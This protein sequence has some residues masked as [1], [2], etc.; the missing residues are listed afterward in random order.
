MKKTIL[1]TGGAGYIGSHT[2]WL[3]SQKN[4]NVVIVDALLHGQ[5][6]KHTWA[7][8]IKADL[9]SVAD[10]LFK[11]YKFDAVMH[12]AA[13]IEVAQSV[14][15][16][17]EY[18]LNNVTGT[19]ALLDSCLAYRM[20]NFIFSSSCAVYGNP[21]TDLLAETHP[22]A[23]LSPYGNTK[24]I[25]ELMLKDFSQAYNFNYTSLRYFNAAGA[26]Q[27]QNLH[28]QHVPETHL[29]PLVLNALKHDKEI[30]I[31]GNDYPTPDST[32]IRD[33]VHVL[34]IA[35][36]HIKA[37]EHMIETKKSDVFNLGT[38]TGSSVREVITLAEKIT[39][40]YANIVEKERRPGDA[41]KLV[42]DATKAHTLL[43]W[44]PIHSDL[45]NIIKSCS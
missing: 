44:N 35:D 13:H 45:E 14:I 9:A 40:K 25:V 2:A 11:Q 7:T 21:Q 18:Y 41:A 31:Y 5:E 15:S 8:F 19:Q 10:T 29:I 26:L 42:A 38:G 22:Y 23:P 24:H 12:F 30:Y 32:A 3:L 43:K 6:F 36:A 20:N 16:P 27:S 33:Y 37:L 34:D 17:R 4:Y 28:E 1:V 39:G